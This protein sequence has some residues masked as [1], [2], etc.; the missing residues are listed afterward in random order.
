MTTDT[1]TR[2]L[3]ATGT[4]TRR[5]RQALID[6]GLGVRLALRSGR[7]GGLRL[8]L[9]AIGVGLC[10]AVLLLGASLDRAQEHRQA[11]T[12]AV[13]PIGQFQGEPAA[14]ARFFVAMTTD[15]TY[16]GRLV[17]GVDLA[18][19]DADPPLPPGIDAFPA[20]G[21]VIV[22]PALR[23]LLASPEGEQL[24]PRFTDPVVGVIGDDGLLSPSDLRFYRGTE[25]PAVV[26]TD[27][28]DGRT[29]GY[30]WGWGAVPLAS[31]D[32]MAGTL[33]RT[34]IVTGAAVVLVPL[35]IFV[36]LM[37]RLG[38]ATRD[39]R[40]TALRIIGGTG[41]QLRR[42]LAG[43]TLVGAISGVCVGVL[44]FLV[45]RRAPWLRIGGGGFFPTDIS[46]SPWLAA[47]VMLGVPAIATASV[48]GGSH[49][50]TI[51][52]R[53]GRVAT[54]GRVLLVVLVAG[55]IGA[56]VATGGLN[57]FGPAALGVTAV[58]VLLTLVL[59]P[60]LLVPLLSWVS[61]LVPQRSLIWVLAGRRLGSDVGTSA[62]AVAGISVVVA[63]GMTMLMMLSITGTTSTNGYHADRDPN[64]Y[65]IQVDA[66]P[67]AD[68]TT[69]LEKVHAVDGVVAVTGG[70]YVWLTGRDSPEGS[71]VFV[72]GC[73]QIERF[74]GVVGCRDDQVYRIAGFGFGEIM[75]PGTVLHPS[76]Q[77]ATADNSFTLPQDVRDIEPTSAMD[78][79]APYLMVTPSA[80]GSHIDAVLADSFGHFVVD[81]DRPDALD[82]LRNAVG[83]LGGRATV[84]SS[85][86][87]A[88]DG[89]RVQ[90]TSTLQTGLILGGGLTLAVALA[91]LL[92]VAIEQLVGRRRALTLTVAAG[93][94][95]SVLA[96]SVLV[97]ALIT[98][99]TGA[100]L[101][102]G[103]GLLLAWYVSSILDTVMSLDVLTVL[104][105]AGAA[106]LAT[107]LVTA[108]TLPAL[109][110][111]TR[112]E[113]LRTE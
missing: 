17:S 41:G 24:R 72:A 37:S 101:G 3:P 4:A 71:E 45:A 67:A 38:A 62:R 78:T 53:V 40:T 54:P 8:T 20:P 27:L 63:A 97:G 1:P 66:V 51:E 39:R 106:V 81:T 92:V 52:R 22:S 102:T 108:A 61:G 104:A 84:T 91:G 12:E 85:T 112:L 19:L 86:E 110:T 73:D 43:E 59:I 64:R 34:A 33:I 103:V 79:Y 88:A 89:G 9:T 16:R 109:S 35:L 94:P 105:I 107:V 68:V 111:L 83:S 31:G 6:L 28:T 50:V 113:S 23:D 98:G 30:S 77:R 13:T 2:P 36:S 76:S 57:R 25:P 48:M 87:W 99:T 18:A 100:L 5:G 26:D 42:I 14:G 49:F 70:S 65:Q 95:R 15:Q 11:R 29:D 7:T 96:R 58:T 74:T 10:V 82:D 47:A 55:L 75:G 69:V 21:T 56:Q 46:P 32:L 93:V 60:V 90:L 44:M 80:L